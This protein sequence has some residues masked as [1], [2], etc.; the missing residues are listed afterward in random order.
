MLEGA[1]EGRLHC[2]RH[3]HLLYDTYVHSPAD[4]LNAVMY[5]AVLNFPMAVRRVAHDGIDDAR[6]DSRI[7]DIGQ[8]LRHSRAARREDGRPIPAYNGRPLPLPPTADENAR[9]QRVIK[10][11]IF[12]KSTP[13]SEEDP[14]GEGAASSTGVHDAHVGEHLEEEK[15]KVAARPVGVLGVA[16]KGNS[17]PFSSDVA[18]TAR[19][20]DQSRSFRSR[21]GDDWD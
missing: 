15:R 2:H 20:S 9:C 19:R 21:L 12:G 7:A 10:G 14:R 3:H 13:C 17:S 8:D 6:V 1:H 16:P 5:E 4:H 11:S 18:A